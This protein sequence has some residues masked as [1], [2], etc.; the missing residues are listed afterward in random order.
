MMNMMV[1]G[2]DESPEQ[3]VRLMRLASK[4]RMKLAGHKERMIFQ[5]DHLHQIPVR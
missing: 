3:G 2:R 1:R 4:F 5:L